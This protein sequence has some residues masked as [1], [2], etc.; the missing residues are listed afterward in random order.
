MKVLASKDEFLK[1]LRDRIRS[2]KV[3]FF[4]GAGISRNSGLYLAKELENYISRK[5]CDDLKLT[6][7]YYSH[8]SDIVLPFE[9][10]IK[11][12][13]DYPRGF[14]DAFAEIH[15]LGKPNANHFLV[16][17]L[18]KD[19]YVSE[20]LTT[21]FD[22]LLEDSL[23]KIGANANVLMDE[24]QFIEFQTQKGVL[25]F[26]GKIHGSVDSPNSM[27]F[28]LDMISRRVLL[29]SRFELFEHF[30]D[31]EDIDIVFLGYSCSDEFD[32]NVFL[33]TIRPS[34]NVIHIEHSNDSTFQV[35]KLSYP[36]DRYQGYKIVV[37]TDEIVSELSTQFGLSYKRIV[38]SPKW[39][40]TINQ[41]CNSIPEGAKHYFLGRILSDLAETKI[42]RIILEKGLKKAEEYDMAR[43][44]N[45]LARIAL[46]ESDYIDAKSIYKNVSQFLKN[47]MKKHT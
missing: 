38:D 14:F 40:P 7:F 19:G 6:S 8:F 10:F 12:L 32:I 35:K 22:T 9:A 47:I 20:V 45:T 39:I 31:R 4:L 27:R 42:S 44:E 34:A 15:K 16:S 41:W 13:V 26:I 46:I 36:F 1:Y 3:S 2:R 30:F 28:T 37:N 5:L 25:P 11:I 33:K 29:Q 18:I 21:N 24:K 17:R 43:I 23:R